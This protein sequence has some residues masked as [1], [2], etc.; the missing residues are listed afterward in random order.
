[1]ASKTDVS[2]VQAIS[3]DWFASRASRIAAARSP[4]SVRQS[5]VA[6][7]QPP[8]A[9]QAFASLVPSSDIVPSQLQIMTLA[10]D[11]F[12]EKNLLFALWSGLFE[13][14]LFR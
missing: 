11:K 13:Y 8:S 5:E 10:S 9:P 4:V 14:K 2:C 7:V 6:I 1:M 3:K 12:I